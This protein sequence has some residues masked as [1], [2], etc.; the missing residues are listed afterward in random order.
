MLR[1]VKLLALVAMFLEALSSSAQVTTSALSGVVTD[2][3]QQAMIG[4]TITALHTPSGTNCIAVIDYLNQFT[5]KTS[6]E[7]Q[8]QIYYVDGSTFDT[9]NSNVD[10]I[11]FL[12]FVLLINKNMI[13]KYGRKSGFTFEFFSK[14]GKRE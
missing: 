12:F 2:E 6:K 5:E 9:T 13:I 4:A 3:N 1:T 8:P 14:K 11:I 10:S 7:I